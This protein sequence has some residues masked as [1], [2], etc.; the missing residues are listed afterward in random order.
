MPLLTVQPKLGE[1]KSRATCRKWIRARVKTNG[2]VPA[3]RTRDG[4]LSFARRLLPPLSE[5]R[6]AMITPTDVREWNEALR[7]T[8]KITQSARIHSVLRSIL[9]YAVND[10]IIQVS[11]CKVRVAGN[12]VSGIEVKPPRRRAALADAH[13]L[14]TASA[15]VGLTSDDITSALERLAERYSRETE[16][17]VNVDAGQ[18][19]AIA[20][21]TKEVVLRCAQE[22]LANVRT[23]APATRATIVV[24]TNDAGFTVTVSVLTRRPLTPVLVLRA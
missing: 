16:L 15:P 7:A 13:A 17:T 14:V 3:P 24:T 11:P 6:I 18:L 19:P 9:D 12:A 20:R 22:A 8:G 1:Q 2:G 10:E 4:Y 23:H 5:K 21:E